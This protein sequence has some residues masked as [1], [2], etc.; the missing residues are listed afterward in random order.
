VGAVE[1][2]HVTALVSRA[3]AALLV[4]S[5]CTP[6]L[7]LSKKMKKQLMLLEPSVRLEQT[8]DTGAMERMK[9]DRTP[10]RVDRVVAYAFEQPAVTDHSVTAPGAAFRSRGEWY[11][12]SYKCTTDA[13]NL[14]VQAL[15]Y[16]IGERV[17]RDQWEKANLYN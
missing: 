12:F 16:A 2:N 7:A 6:A 15:T 14:E 17:P 5:A 3:L 10:Y 11:R 4:V 8:C 9:Q 1:G 13:E